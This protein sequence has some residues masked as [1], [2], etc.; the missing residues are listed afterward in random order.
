[1]EILLLH[2]PEAP[3]IGYLISTWKS[4]QTIAPLASMA[5]ID[6]VTAPVCMGFLEIVTVPDGSTA[7]I[8]TGLPTIKTEK[9][10]D[11][12]S[13]SEKFPATSTVII[14][15]PGSIV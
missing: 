13:G 11:S 10:K 12:P 7:A 4:S 9:V 14:G 1:V 15:I 3:E 6:T 8:A 2:V 5:V